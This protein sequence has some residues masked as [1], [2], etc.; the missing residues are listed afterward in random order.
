MIGPIE[1][2]WVAFDG[3]VGWYPKALRNSITYVP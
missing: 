2:K 1:V 3:K